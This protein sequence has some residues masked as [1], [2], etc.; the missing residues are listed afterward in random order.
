MADEVPE[1]P[2]EQARQLVAEEAVLLDVREQGEWDAGH[3]PQAVHLP[4]G[5]VRQAAGFE[6]GRRIVVVCRSGVRSRTAAKQLRAMGFD[7]VNLTGGMRDWAACG[8]EV[9]DRGGQPGVVV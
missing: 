8:G 3:A 7:A 4:L 1:I 9:V 2:A 5:R 6:P